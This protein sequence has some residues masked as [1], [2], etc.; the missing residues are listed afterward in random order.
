MFGPNISGTFTVCTR[1]DADDRNEATGAFAV[2]DGGG[3]GDIYALGDTRPKWDLSATRSSSVYG[4]ST[5]V[6]PPAIR[7]LPCIKI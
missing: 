1:N 4:G 7:V 6:Q 2:T 5:T 3:R